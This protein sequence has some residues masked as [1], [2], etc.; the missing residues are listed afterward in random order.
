MRYPR[1]RSRISFEINL[2]CQTVER[3]P[4]VGEKQQ[5]CVSL[6]YVDGAVLDNT[7]HLMAVAMP[8]PEAMWRIREK[9]ISFS[10]LLQFLEDDFLSDLNERWKKA[11]SLI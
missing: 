6:I 9:T 7:T 8:S 10:K 11:D 5:P 1:K 4:D 2:S 3:V